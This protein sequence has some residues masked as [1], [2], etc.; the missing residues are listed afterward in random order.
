MDAE[1]ELVLGGTGFLGPHLV[2]A[3]VALG[4]RVTVAARRP[5]PASLRLPAGVD[6]V[7]V[8]GERPGALVEDVARGKYARI[9]HLAALSRTDEAEAA[10]ARALR[11]NRDWPAELAAAATAAG[12]PYV[13]ASTDLVFGGRPPADALGYGPDEA[14]APV[15]VY[16]RSKAAGEEAV[17]ASAEGALV[18]RLPLLF[19]DSRGRALGASDGLFEALAR[20]VTA[21]LFT[22]EWRT[23]LDVVAAARGLVALERM[24]CT[25]RWHLGGRGVS[26]FELGCA[27]CLAAELDPARL[28]PVQRSNLGL[29]ET[30]AEDARLDTRATRALGSELSIC[31]DSGSAPH[32][33]E[34]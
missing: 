10:P 5:P 18:V 3:I 32:F 7:S 20:G 19:G 16:G 29:A 6:F 4:R 30:R 23:P 27:L 17:L 28:E 15:G 9:F 21:R 2:D 33:R 25:G 13:W 24:G 14:P 12:V 8:D 11:L 22:D 31:L 26:R 34:S 1:R